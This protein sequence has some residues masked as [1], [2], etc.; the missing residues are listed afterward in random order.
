MWS[1]DLVVDYIE[2]REIQSRSFELYGS[3]EE[4]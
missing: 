3:G 4:R 1:K 2:D